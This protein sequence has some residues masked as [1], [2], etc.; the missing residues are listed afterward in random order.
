MNFWI[1]SDT[2]FGH[3]MLYKEGFRPEGFETTILRNLRNNIKPEDVLIHLGD[4]CFYREEYWHECLLDIKCKK[5]L[6]RGNHDKK[7]TTWY[8]SHGW[9]FVANEIVLAAFGENILFSHKPIKEFP[10][11]VNIHGH[12]HEGNHHPEFELTTKHILISMEHTY[13]PVNLRKLIKR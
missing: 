1:I 2:H 4:V 11:D 9:D 6:V 5:W 10:Y 7:T 13:T 12:L 3:D 8:L